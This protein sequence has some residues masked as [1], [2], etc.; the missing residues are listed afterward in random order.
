MIDWRSAVT[1]KLGAPYRGRGRG[2][3]ATDFS[4]ATEAPRLVSSHPIPLM[5]L[6]S[7][8]SFPRAQTQF[9]HRRDVSA[10]A[11]HARAVCDRRRASLAL[12]LPHDQAH[13]IALIMQ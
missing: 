13:D 9:L 7:S 12:S 6:S 5:I 10:A 4:S 1:H 11:R 3:A 8:A 2:S